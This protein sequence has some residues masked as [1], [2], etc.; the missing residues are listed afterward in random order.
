MET[1]FR[2]QPS[3]KGTLRQHGKEGIMKQ[4]LLLAMVF[5]VSSDQVWAQNGRREHHE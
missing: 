3:S 1:G 4:I 5:F 2:L